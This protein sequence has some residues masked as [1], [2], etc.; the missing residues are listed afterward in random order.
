MCYDQHLNMPT[1][2]TGIIFDCDGVII[3]SREANTLYYNMLLKELG[4]P[5]LTDKQEA[6]THMSTVRGALERI[7]PQNLHAKALDICKNVLDYQRDIM[8]KISLEEGFLNFIHWC[9]DN[10]INTAVHTNRFDGM[11]AVI[12]TFKLEG[13]FDPIITAADAAPK[14][15]PAGIEIILNKWQVSKETVIFIGDSLNDQRAAKAGEVSFIAHKNPALDAA[16]N[17]DSFSSLQKLL[18]KKYLCI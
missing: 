3:N 6:F 13:L 8:P 4:L 10:G 5:P 16:V 14:P 12:K 18:H 7:I 2:L 17:S 9:L 1:I 15:D 11:P